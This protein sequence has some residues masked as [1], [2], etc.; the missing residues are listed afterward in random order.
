VCCDCREA[1]TNSYKYII[2]LERKEK[3]NKSWTKK[4]KKKKKRKKKK[5]KKKKQVKEKKNKINITARGKENSL[6]QQKVEMGALYPKDVY[7]YTLY[8]K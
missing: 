4:K 7:I 8:S 2:R 1:L 6:G 5:K 3:R